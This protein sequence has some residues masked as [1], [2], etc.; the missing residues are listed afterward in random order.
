LWA[1]DAPLCRV[2]RDLDELGRHGGPTR[3]MEDV[4]HRMKQ[5]T[6]SALGIVLAAS[7]LAYAAGE[8]P[9]DQGGRSSQPAPRTGSGAHG[10]DST[11][12]AGNTGSAPGPRSAADMNAPAASG[13]RAAG[14]QASQQSW[15]ANMDRG[16]IAQL[17]RELAA[18]GMYQGAADGI[19]G[20][21][22]MAAL[23]RFQQQQGFATDKGLD[24]QTRQ[25]LGLQ[26]DRQSVSGAQT[27]ASPELDRPV[28]RDEAV[29]GTKTFRSQVPLEALNQDQLRTVQ[30]RLQELGFY[31]GQVDGVF[32]QGTRAAV[33]RF[34]QT[35]TDLA[36]R[37]MISDITAGVFG[38]SPREL[39][40]AV[41]AATRAGVGPKHAQGANA[42][43]S[44]AAQGNNARGTETQG[45]TNQPSDM[46]RSRSSGTSTPQQGGTATPPQGGTGNPQPAPR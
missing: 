26:L 32:G 31:Q 12:T 34:F 29:T 36:G 43:Q 1:F 25:A 8:Q 35:Q 21:Q 14:D 22:T 15:A 5:L 18:R 2:E 42:P 38:L 23:T 40:P 30:T 45:T 4:M 46:Q 28:G 6:S 9:V 44:G 19:A 37:G 17:Q 10:S 11:S 3:P 39:D 16:Q 20:P 33:Q 13:T 27:S 7:G 41:P 24:E